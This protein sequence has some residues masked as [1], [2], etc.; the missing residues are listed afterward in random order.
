MT[1]ITGPRS[2]AQ[3]DTAHV[4]V[5]VQNVG[6]VDVTAPFNIELSDGWMTPVVA[7]ATVPG[8]AA[9]ASTTVEI[10]WNTAG[11]AVT[12]HI[13]FANSKL[14]D[15]NS[16]NNSVGTSINV[17]APGPPGPPPPPPPPPPGTDVAI[18]GITGPARVTQGDTAHIVVTVKN[19]GGQDVT[20]N[21]DVV[22]ADGFNGP[23]VATQTITGLAVGVSVTR[24]LDWN[25]AGVE[26]TGHTLFATQ[27]LADSDPSN[28]TVGIAVIV[29]APPVTDVAVSSVVA[30]AAVTQGSTAS[31][32]VTV[33]N[34]GGLNVSGNFDVVLTD[35]TAGVTLG[36]QTVAGLAVGATATRTFN[37]NTTGAAVGGHRLVATHSLSDANAANNLGGATITVN[38]P[39]IDVAVTDVSAPASVTQ[40]GTVAAQVTVQNVGGQ[41]VGST[42]NV[43]LTDATAGVTIGT[44]SVTGL[45]IGASATRSFSWN[46]TGATLGGH[47]LVAAQTFTD[48]N[49]ANNQRSATVTVNPQPGIHGTERGWP[50]CDH[51]LRRRVD[52]RDGGRH[53]DR[54]ADDLRARRRCQRD[55]HVQLEYR[56]RGDQRAYPD[57]NPKTGRQR[58]EQQRG[59]DRDQRERAEPPRRESQRRCH[60]QWQQLVGNRSDHGTRLPAQPRERC[61]RARSV[62][63]SQS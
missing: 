3:G 39:V 24:T 55:T 54:N 49:A 56:R 13:L 50:G 19:V 6:E 17:T 23:V 37:W 16:A 1:G 63:W 43:V 47:T 51:Q 59:R 7:V 25:T 30:P 28:N 62:E 9:G 11:A 18:T 57:G 41:N 53:H 61:E 38:A 4:V 40:G 31:V 34:V 26:I 45:A 2:V 20:G 8:L 32:A 14:A 22:L 15:D 58:P 52:R 48:D 44:Q 46:T 36:T 27:R 12:G 5:T 33:Q 60:Q 35:S 10:L 29:Q 42:F 21:F